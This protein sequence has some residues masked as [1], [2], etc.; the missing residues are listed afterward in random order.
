MRAAL[1]I[2]LLFFCSFAALDCAAQ[3]VADKARQTRLAELAEVFDAP[4]PDLEAMLAAGRDPFF[5][6]PLV[7][8]TQGGDADAAKAAGE[9]HAVLLRAAAFKL[10]ASGHIVSGGRAFVACAGGQL[11]RVGGTVQVN[12]AGQARQFTVISSDG[13]GY[14]LGIADASLYSPY[15]DRAAAP[16]AAPSSESSN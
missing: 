1:R 16:K 13:E 15:N 3:V 8:V 7:V 9:D 14:T 5:P 6:P 4:R 10:Q 12:V 11:L 2:L